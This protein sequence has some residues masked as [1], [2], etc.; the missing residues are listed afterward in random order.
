MDSF[1]LLIDE[2]KNILKMVDVIDLILMGV[3]EKE[4]ISIEDF[5]DILYFIKN[6]A[7]EF[8][9]A[10][11]EKILFVKMEEEL[12]EAAYKLIEYGMLVEHQM[13]RYYISELGKAL[14]R[15]FIAPTTYEK[16]QIITYATSWTE[17]LRRHIEKEDHVVYPF[18]K[19]HLSNNIIQQVN[20]EVERY[21]NEN[22][23]KEKIHLCETIL[24]NLSLKYHH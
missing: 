18:A 5:N 9:H 15:Y 20:D 23:F 21:S 11:E 16:L 3:L 2:H 4:D 10:K 6:Y 13:A 12:R 19:N 24:T 22:H 7:D 8:H 1:E 17:L 14:K